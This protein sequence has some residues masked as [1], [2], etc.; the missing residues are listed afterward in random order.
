MPE[1]KAITLYQPWADLVAHGLKKF[2]T[3]GWKTSHR[4]LL[5]IH[6]GKKWG[7]EESEY[8]ARFRREY[9]AVAAALSDT[10]PLGCLVAKVN[11]LD[12]IPVEEIRDSLTA[13]ER[14]FG[15]YEDGRYAWKLELLNR[16]DVPLLAQ[17][18]QGLWTFKFEN[19]RVVG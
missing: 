5:F 11:L 8:A 12:C 18:K 19:G 10:V 16:P 7:S 14:A 1:Y 9:P 13:Q 17:G 6:A 2:E 3:R 4:G 15:N